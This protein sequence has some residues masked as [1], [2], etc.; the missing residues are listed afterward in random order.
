[1]NSRLALGI[2]TGGTYTD[3]VVIDYETREIQA[4]A[5][6]R[7][8]PHD[9][10]LGIAQSLDALQGVDLKT[11]KLVSLS[12]T[13]ATNA[14]VEGKGCR[15]FLFLVGYDPAL[16][17]KFGFE[18]D[19]PTADFCYLRGKHD[20]LGEEI[21]ALDLKEAERIIIDEKDQVEAFAISSYLGVR[22]PE[23]ELRLRALIQRLTPHPVVCGHELTSELDSIQRAITAVLNARLIPLLHALIL[24]MRKVLKRKGI[25]A[26]LMLVKGDGSLVSSRIAEERPVETILSGPAAS[27]AAAQ[28]LSGLEEAVIIDMGG[29]TTDVAILREGKPYLNPRGATVGNRSTCVKGIDVTTAG[30]GGDSRIFIDRT[31]DLRVGPRR[32]VPIGLLASQY[33]QVLIELKRVAAGPLVDRFLAY[34]DFFVIANPVRK[35]H[36]GA[37]E[38]EALS[39]LQEGP[40][41]LLQLSSRLNLIYPTLLNLSQLEERGVVQRC[42]LTPSDLLHVEGKLSLWDCEASHWAFRI[43]AKAI[44]MKEEDLARLVR[45]KI[46]QAVSLQV[47]NK[48]LRPEGPGAS[49]PGCRVCSDLLNLLFRTSTPAGSGPSLQVKLHKKLV[50][51][52]A[53]V[54]SFL[55]PVA[56]A[57]G[58]QVLIP[59]HAEVGNALGAVIGIFHKTI[60]IWIKPTSRESLREGYSVHLPNEKAF[61]DRLEQAKA[62]A[63][64]KGKLLAEK[65]A[66]KAGAEKIRIEVSE[67]DNFGTV[68]EEMGE[69]IYLDSLI[70]ISAFG[71]PAIAK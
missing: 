32:V 13:L 47:L 42:G 35:D 53:P 51:I 50:A 39:F 24:S 25:Q 17:E 55:P 43:L 45:E 56:Q 52:G 63:V 68:A 30:I 12:T 54:K 40:L 49:L 57:L 9:L 11:I 19:L 18:K 58:T 46:T 48:A 3:A 34:G 26:S 8:T 1:M 28:Y 22:N 6:A 20:L 64:Q 61:F 38:R 23:H 41:S 44:R 29:T 70:R 15:V 31:G 21:E 67:R 71:R 60:E 4:K 14:I 5:K 36:L 59:P 37:R 10:S 62:Y 7:T 66:K 16:M 33:P 69:G 65:E 2:D 27:V